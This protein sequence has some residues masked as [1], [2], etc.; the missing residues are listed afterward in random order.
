MVLLLAN[1]LAQGL[2]ISGGFRKTDAQLLSG[3]REL[4]GTLCPTEK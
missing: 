3:I 4:H 2:G 1:P